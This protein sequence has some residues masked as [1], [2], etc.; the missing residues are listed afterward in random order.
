MP[1]KVLVCRNRREKCVFSVQN[2]LY[3]RLHVTMSTQ[4]LDADNS[5]IFCK[6]RTFIKLFFLT[7]TNYSL[8]KISSKYSVTCDTST[9]A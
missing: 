2:V 4:A 6:I 3:H 8:Y 1:V 9:K 5:T 7:L